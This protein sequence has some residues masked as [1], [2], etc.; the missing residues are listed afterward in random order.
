MKSEYKTPERFAERLWLEISRRIL[1]GMP[2]RRIEQL[3][4]RH[5]FRGDGKWGRWENEKT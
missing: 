2:Y 5:G 3:K 4:A 1:M